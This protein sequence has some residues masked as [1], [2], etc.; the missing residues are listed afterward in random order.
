MTLRKDPAISAGDETV[1]SKPD[2][3]QKSL[4]TRKVAI[5]FETALDSFPVEYARMMS[6]KTQT[7][8]MLL[9]GNDS[10]TCKIFWNWC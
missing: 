6:E 3:E 7:P 1:W 2:S 4:R 5:D 10:V 8:M 9:E